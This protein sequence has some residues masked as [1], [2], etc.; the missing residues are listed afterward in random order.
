VKFN[1]AFAVL[2]TTVILSLLAVVILPTPALAAPAIALSPTSGTVGTNVAIVG[3]NFASYANDQVH[4][5]FGNTEVASNTVPPNGEFAW[6]F[7]VPDDAAPGTTLVTVKYGGNQLAK[8]EFLVPQPRIT[9]DKGGGVVGTK[10]T[11]SGEGFLASQ[12]IVCTYTTS[13]D[14]TIYLGSATTNYIGEFSLAFDIPESTGKEHEVIA[15]DT[16]GNKAE[17][18]FNVI[19]SAV[20]EPEAGAIGDS[21]VATGTG[22]GQNSRISIDF[23]QKQVVTDKTDAKGSFKVNFSAPDMPLQAYTVTISDAEG[24]IAVTAFTINAG[25]PS[26]VFPQWGI[27]TLIGLVAVALFILGIWVGRKYAYSY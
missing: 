6:T 13:N 16:A 3:T 11:I 27:Y 15:T 21:V 7:E 20:L 10:V 8:A 22:F 4:I 18:P 14:A 25:E 24:N 5:Y 2:A 19:P 17:T 1:K 9:L 23:G 26:F 12:E